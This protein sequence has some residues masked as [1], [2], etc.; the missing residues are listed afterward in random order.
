MPK[1]TLTGYMQKNWQLHY[2]H[3]G[4]AWHPNIIRKKDVK[5]FFNMEEVKITIEK[6]N[7]ILIN[8]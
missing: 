7:D 5:S 6:T 3:N 2:E 1:K 4:V 8:N